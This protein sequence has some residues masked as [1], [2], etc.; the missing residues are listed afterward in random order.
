MRMTHSICDYIALYG[1]FND[2]LENNALST[3]IISNDS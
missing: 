2:W 1:L 3:N